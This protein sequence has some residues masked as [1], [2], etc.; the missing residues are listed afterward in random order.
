MIPHQP[1]NDMSKLTDQD[2]IDFA[3]ASARDAFDQRDAY[4]DA[5]ASFRENLTDTMNDDDVDGLAQSAA[6]ETYDAEC[7]RFGIKTNGLR[8]FDC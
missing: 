7:V 4:T 2:V 5:V 1:E 3:K 6:L 8:K